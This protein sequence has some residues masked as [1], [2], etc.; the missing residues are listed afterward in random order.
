MI[1]NILPTRQ[2]VLSAKRG[3]NIVLWSTEGGELP[4]DW[5]K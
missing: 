3:T 2:H 5:G 1:R 4:Y